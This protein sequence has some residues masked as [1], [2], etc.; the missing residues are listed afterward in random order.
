MIE[1]KLSPEDMTL[2]MDRSIGATVIGALREAAIEAEQDYYAG[3]AKGYREDYV[4]GYLKT[5]MQ[6][7]RE[8]VA[9]YDREYAEQYGPLATYDVD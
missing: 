9:S 8:A 5:N 2:T 3:R 7:L 1:T 6:R 4:E